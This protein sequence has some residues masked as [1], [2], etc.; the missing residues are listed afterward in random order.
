MMQHSL[1]FI[2]SPVD[3]LCHTP[4]GATNSNQCFCTMQV[5]FFFSKVL[6]TMAISVRMT[7][8]ISSAITFSA[9]LPVF[10]II[11]SFSAP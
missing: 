8:R 5:A 2:T 4:S 7:R 6:S 3:E 9:P 11:V 10:S 1:S